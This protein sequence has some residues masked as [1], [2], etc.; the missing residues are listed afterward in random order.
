MWSAVGSCWSQPYTISTYAGGASPATPMAAVNASVGSIAGV[1]TDVAGSVYFSSSLHCVFKLGQSGVLTRVAG[2]C[3]IGYSGDGGLATGAQLNDPQGLAVDAVGNLYIADRGNARLR[4]VTAAGV[5]TTV[6]GNGSTGYSGDGGPAT[7]ARLN[8]VQGVAVDAAGNVYVSDSF[9][10]RIRKVSSAGIITTVAG[11]GGYG[12]AGDGGLATNAQLS[13]PQGLATDAA[14]NLYIADSSVYRIRKVSPGGVISTVAGNGGVGYMGDGGPA[15]SATFGSPSAVAVDSAGSLFI[16]DGNN[17][18]VRKVSPSGLITTV[19]G[20]GT[21]GYVGDSGLATNA[22]LNYPTSVA[23]D[24]AGNLYLAD[25]N[26]FRLR[27]VSSGGTITTV[28]GDGTAGFSGDS[29]PATSAQFSTAQSV[30]TDA[31]GNVYVADSG[32]HRIRKISTNGVL[33]TVAGN[34]ASG[35]SGDGGPATAAKLKGA[36]GIAT[37]AAGNLYIADSGNQRIRKVSSAGIITTVAG[38]GGYGYG[39]DGGLATNAQL[40]YPSGVAVDAAGNLYIADSNNARVRKVSP[41]GTITTV[42]GNGTPGYSGDGGPATSAQLNLPQDVAIDASGNLYIADSFNNR[43]RKVSPGGVITTVA[44]NGTPGYSGDGGPAAS[45][46]L[47]DARGLA[48]DAAGNLYLADSNNARVRRVTSGGIITTIAGNGTAGYAGDG[49]LATSAQLSYPSGLAVHTGGRIYV[50]MYTGAALRLLTPNLAR[51]DFNGD[52][53]SDVLW[54]NDTTRQV[55]VWYL[56]GAQGNTYLS[57]AW[58]APNGAPGW[59]VVGTA[60]FNGDGKLDLVWQND[61]TRQ[62]AVWYMG[63][64]QGNTFLSD[65]WLASNGPAGWRVAGIADFN[66]DG[67]PDLIWQNDT[68]RQVSVWYM[69]GAQGN[70]FVSDAWLA[71]NGAPGWRVVGFA[72]FNSD[73]KLDLVW[74]NDTTRQVSVWYLG[75]AQGNTFLSDSWLSPNSVTG[76]RVVGTPDLNGDGKPDLVWQ[77]DTTRQ[78]VVWYLGGAQGNTFLSDAWLAQNGPQGWTLIAP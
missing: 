41:S 77:S 26:N 29:G 3:R 60:D 13:R 16:A 78:V 40:S 64:T 5:I 73:G 58:L 12:Y 21:A 62:V 37:D 63:G 36:Q 47:L 4:K 22:Q 43:V 56:G 52:G 28:A 39:G 51:R 67:K 69:G 18:C 8:T 34:G 6:A 49:G 61:N 59:R 54:Q 66:G 17:S 68:T 75:G 2:T 72:D 19:A 11:N 38:S 27:K 31:N 55:S 32:N 10:N 45:A 25:T 44:G 20:N 46:Q 65:A 70:T 50:A 23:A 35:Y 53:K 76:W 48:V 42:A 9:N 1:A 33:T 30:A 71:P 14:G 15:T 7:S 24:A 57:D 74:Q